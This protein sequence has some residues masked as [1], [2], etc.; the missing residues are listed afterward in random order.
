MTQ[1]TIVA[2][3]MPWPLPD[4]PWEMVGFVLKI[5]LLSVNLQ[6]VSFAGLQAVRT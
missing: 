6:G 5:R 4:L 1:F 3:A 2:S